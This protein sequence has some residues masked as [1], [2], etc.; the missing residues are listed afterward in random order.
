MKKSITT[1]AFIIII[2]L[3]ISNT[4]AKNQKQLWGVAFGGQND[5][6]AIFKTD[7]SGNNEMVKYNFV[8]PG[9]NPL[10]L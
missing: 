4:T 3:L 9:G 7:A 2:G 1:T 5:A 6:G 10:A 8:P